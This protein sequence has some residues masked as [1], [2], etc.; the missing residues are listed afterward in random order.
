MSLKKQFDAKTHGINYKQETHTKKL[1][2]KN[3][4]IITGSGVFFSPAAPQKDKPWSSELISTTDSF[5]REK[6]N[7]KDVKKN[8]L[9]DLL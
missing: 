3:I 8:C 9:N 1:L 7:S 6:L 2:F 4:K 5:R